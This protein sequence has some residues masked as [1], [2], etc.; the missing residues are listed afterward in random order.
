MGVDSATHYDRVTDAW[1][2]FMGHDLHFGYFES[3][4]M[5]LAEATDRLID[6][7]LELCDIHEET[8]MLDVG[9][10]I[11]GPA[12]YIHER[13]GCEIHGISTSRRGIQLAREAALKRAW[14]RCT[15]TWPTAWI[16]ASRTTRST[17]CGSWSPPI[18]SPTR[19]PSSGNAVA[20]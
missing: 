1:K 12:F 10:G 15:S 7:M 4:E 5:E 6:K 3:E 16:T 8:R 20:C 13:Y 18:P 9:C 11:G 19:G 2:E 14:T 17:W